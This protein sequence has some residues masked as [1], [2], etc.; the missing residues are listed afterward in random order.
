LHTRF[1]SQWISGWMN[2]TVWSQCLV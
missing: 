2:L 1:F